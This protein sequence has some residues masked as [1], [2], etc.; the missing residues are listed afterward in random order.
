MEL[1]KTDL[2]HYLALGVLYGSVHLIPPDE[3]TWNQGGMRDQFTKILIF[4]R[5]RAEEWGMVLAA[6]QAD[7]ILHLVNLP[8]T[9]A[10]VVFQ[11]MKEL[12]SRIQ[13]YLESRTALI[14]PEAQRS[15]YDK[16][17]AGWEAVILRFPS[18]LDNIQEAG[19]CLVS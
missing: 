16:P 15:Y 8:D 19:K 10:K 18:T 5:Q 2:Q 9:T 3:I 17:T 6:R 14:I 11:M 13:H 7:E 1:L 12:M 4:S